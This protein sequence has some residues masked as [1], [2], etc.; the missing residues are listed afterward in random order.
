[1][2]C[3]QVHDVLG[4]WLQTHQDSVPLGSFQGDLCHLFLFIPR[5]VV[6]DESVCW[7]GW[8][9][10]GYVYAGGGHVRKVQM[11]D[12]AE[13]CKAEKMMVL[14]YTRGGGTTGLG[15]PSD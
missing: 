14:K 6:Q 9:T 2:D 4:G 12:G 8:V 13:A 10:P 15:E 3:H 1:M 5:A 11:G 7:R